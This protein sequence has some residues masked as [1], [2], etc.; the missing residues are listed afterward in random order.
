MISRGRN[1]EKELTSNRVSASCP[2]EKSVGVKRIN[3]E[4]KRNAYAVKPAVPNR[5][6]SVSIQRKYDGGTHRILDYL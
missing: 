3:W 5:D 6:G 2:E 4:K 1:I